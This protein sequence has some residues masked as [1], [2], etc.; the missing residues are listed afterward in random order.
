MPTA[1]CGGGSVASLACGE[2]SWLQPQ[3]SLL[4][5]T[6]STA[7]YGLHSR[8]AA[9]R[10]IIH[11]SH[12]HT[13]VTFTTMPPTY[14]SH[15]PK[16]HSQRLSLFVTGG[17]AD[18]T[19]SKDPQTGDRVWKLARSWKMDAAGKLGHRREALRVTKVSE[20]VELPVLSDS[21]LCESSMLLS[22]CYIDI[23]VACFFAEFP[24]L[25]FLA[26]CG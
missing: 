20:R 4:L 15:L 2:N 14:R 7:I 6:P 10:H 18:P 25:A 3:F 1:A 13:E 22:M 23:A 8:T 16:L 26:R 12:T 21:S 19:S 9:K 11:N 5:S 17:R 24:R